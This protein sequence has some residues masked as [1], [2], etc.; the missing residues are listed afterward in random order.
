MAAGRRT[1]AARW[2]VVGTLVVVLAALPELIG[3]LPASDA[4]VGAAEL[5]TRVMASGVVAFSGYAEATGGLSLPVTDQLTSVADLFSERTTMR[6]W[7][8]GQADNRVDVVTPTGETGTHTGPGGSWTW[9]YERATATRTLPT[10]L[11]LPA[12]PDLVPSALGERL[13][14]EATDAEL[15]RIGARR[16]AGRDALGLRV[17]PAA[18][19]SSVSAVDVWVDGRTGLPLQVRVIGRQGDRAALDTRFLDISLAT[20]APATTAFTPPDGAVVRIGQEAEVLLEAGRR[21]EPTPLPATLAGL[22]RRRLDGVPEGIALYG[23]GITLLAVAPVPERL[24]DG[25]R[26][27]LVRSPQAVVD[28][29]GVRVAAGPVGLMLV[30]PATRAPYVLTGTVTPAA[31]AAAAAALPG[32]GGSR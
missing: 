26:D 5:R 14:S 19:A 16:V 1:A 18:P 6:I 25:L 30:D 15:S 10:P 28:A 11:T 32:L 27:A 9:E 8:R 31:L 7:W 3:L 20:P 21:I 12:P 22:P 17:T 23:R 29:A 4:A 2:A 13:L 24:A